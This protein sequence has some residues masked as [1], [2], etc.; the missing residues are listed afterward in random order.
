MAE[1]IPNE[2]LL[3]KYLDEE[4]TPEDRA[5]VEDQL[6]ND[7][8]LRQQLESLRLAKEAVRYYGLHSDVARVRARWEQSHPLPQRRAKAKVVAIGKVWRY[9][10][11][12]AAV[13]VAIIGI[14][15]FFRPSLSAD[16]IY[17]EAY[18]QYSPGSTRSQQQ[19]YTPIEQA[20]RSKNY[21]E[22]IRLSQQG[23]LSTKE[24]LITGIAYLEEHQPEKS[25]PYFE[26]VRQDSGGT[27]RPDGEFYLGLAYLKTKQYDK[28]LEIL[29]KIESDPTHLYHQQVSEKM[30]HEIEKLR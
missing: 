21:P 11:A 25:V 2:D 26:Q 9:G 8:Q 18:V 14:S 7:A 6:K 23:N 17:E 19:D 15:I 20:Y 29:R 4:L 3:L 10:L 28:S 16:K 24:Q 27:Y 13:V 30:L 22:V 5:G 1:N 12:V